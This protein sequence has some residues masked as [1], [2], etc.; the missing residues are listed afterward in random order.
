MGW[1]LAIGVG[2]W[3]G[4]DG[5]DVGWDGAVMEIAGAAELIG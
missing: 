5:L 2:D 3:E 1:E 4:R